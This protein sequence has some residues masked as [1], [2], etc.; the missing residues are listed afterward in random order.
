[1][2][3]PLPPGHHQVASKKKNFRKLDTVNPK[4][5]SHRIEMQRDLVVVILYD[6]ICNQY[7]IVTTTRSRCISIL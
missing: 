4:N 2:F 6:S 7:K 3:R 1:M 5:E